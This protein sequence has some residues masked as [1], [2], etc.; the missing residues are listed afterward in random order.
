MISNWF[1]KKEPQDL[2]DFWN[3]YAK[4]FDQKLPEKISDVRFVVLDTE[5]TGF[6][7]KED[8]MLCIGAV[9]VQHNQIN[10]A[11][12]FEIYIEQEKFNPESVEIHGIIKNEKVA[13]LSEEEA[14]KHFLNYIENAVLVAHHA[15]FDIT[16]INKALK[17]MGLPK[18]KNRILDTMFLYRRTRITSNLIDREKNYSLDEIAEA[19]TIDV[20]DRHT[21]AGDAFI[22]AIA[23]LKILGRLNKN[24]QMK[25]KNLF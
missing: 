5:T 16:M 17:R 8:R 7:Y 14:V 23:F 15:N 2:P 11:D 21:A 4:N 22:T 3:T 6:D 10:M 20:S 19:Y 9:S 13:T 1:K 24:G 25:L 12:N 18:L